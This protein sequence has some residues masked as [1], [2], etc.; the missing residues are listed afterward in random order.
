MTHRVSRI[1]GK[2]ENTE[3]FLRIALYQGVAKVGAKTT[4][5]LPTNA[6]SRG[7]KR[8]PTVVACAYGKHRLYLFS[9]REPEDSEQ[10]AAGRSVAGCLV[11]TA[12]LWLYAGCLLGSSAAFGAGFT[13]S[14]LPPASACCLHTD[15]R[16]PKGFE[17]AARW[18][19]PALGSPCVL[20]EAISLRWDQ[21]LL[22]DRVVL[23]GRAPC[24]LLAMHVALTAHCRTQTGCSRLR[25]CLQGR[26]AR[27]NKKQVLPSGAR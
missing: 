9:C 16:E 22:V 7:P 10:A 6:D 4:A 5:R 8:D 15:S 23:H 12:C 2:V 21:K 19:T 3:R 26:P 24:L 1:I 18:A 25:C 11:L 20:A 14:A 17:H 13:A 27:H